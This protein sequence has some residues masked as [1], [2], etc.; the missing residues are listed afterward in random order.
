MLGVHVGCA[1]VL[2]PACAPS[3]HKL[4]P[5][6]SWQLLPCLTAS[7]TLPLFLHHPPTIFSQQVLSASSLLPSPTHLPQPLSS[8]SPPPWHPSPKTSFR[9]PEWGILC[10]NI[11]WS[12]VH[13][14]VFDSGML[15]HIDV[16]NNNNKIFIG[17][18]E[19]PPKMGRHHCVGVHVL[20][21]LLNEMQHDAVC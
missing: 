18:Y 12:E 10:K 7:I 11:T 21:C 19:N 9:T 4:F 1:T 3:L 5:S 2:C 15:P 16:Q 20:V 14:L 6:P 8:E 17:V 13:H